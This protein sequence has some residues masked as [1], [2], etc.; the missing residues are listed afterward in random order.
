MPG[1]ADRRP[2]LPLVVAI[3]IGSLVPSLVACV[4]LP[5]PYRE[6]P[7]Y[8]VRFADV[9]AITLIP[10]LVS[11][12]SMS[13]GNVEQEVQEWSDAVYAQSLDA[14]RDQI[15]AMGKRFVPFAGAQ[16]PRP[17]F[18][19]GTLDANAPKP[20]TP[21]NESWLLFESAKESILRHTYD[22]VQIFPDQ[23]KSF[24]YTLGEASQALLSGT[25][26]DAYL[27]MIATDSIPTGE[28]TALIGVGAA[29]TLYTGS[30]AGPGATPAELTIALVDAPSG[31]ILFF[32]R[33]SMPL[34]D[35]RDP[36]TNAKLIELVLK[37]MDR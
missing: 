15:E 6:A 18:R 8:P 10:P 14:V 37:G 19:V 1:V 36:A 22:P 29:A 20:S 12:Y 17:D 3:L 30:Y 25:E 31:D 27:L 2:L 32:N 9:E 33:V 34:S 5:P 16:G 4:A 13:S 11:V 23:M 35:L 24:E 26:A 7:D 21:A 28:R